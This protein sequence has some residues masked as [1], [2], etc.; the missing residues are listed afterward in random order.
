MSN[1]CL[2]VRYGELFLKGKNRPDFAQKLV[3]NINLSFQKNNLFNFNIRKFHDQLIITAKNDKELSKTFP[4][5]KKIFGISTFY[6]A[7]QLENDCEKLYKFVENITDYYEINFTTFKFDISRG[8]KSFPKNSLTLQKELGGIIVK[9]QGLKV[10]LNNPQKTFYIRV[11]REFTLFFTEKIKGLGGLPVGSSGRVLLLL[12]GGID[13]PVAAYQL[14][15]RGLEVVYL[16]FYHQKEGQ[17]KVFALGEKLSP[18]NNFSKQVYL[19]DAQPLFTEISH[20]SQEKYRLIVLKRMFIRCACFLAE[21]LAITALATGDSLAQ[22][23]SQTLESLAVIQQA[24]I[25]AFEQ[26]KYLT[27]K[28]TELCHDLE[29]ETVD[30]KKVKSKC[31]ELEKV[32]KKLR[33][34]KD[35][36]VNLLTPL[37]SYDKREIIAEAQRIG[38]Y[39]ISLKKYEDCCSLFEP[40]HPV[41]RPRKEVVEKLEEEIL[42]PEI[43]EIIAKK[44]NESLGEEP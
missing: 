35:K 11:Y 34:E 29:K 39:E 9:E 1:Q 22:V 14:M 24:S 32:V 10:N 23:A 30:K 20:I 42:W 4:C 33:E 15:K 3:N 37:I 19:I 17:E 7:Y 27:Q 44:I 6:L 21:K 36:Q 25:T 5:L 2:I 26:I 16:H 28:I 31:Q 38:T 18:Y 40:N 43:L 41:T 13:S 12:S 8:D